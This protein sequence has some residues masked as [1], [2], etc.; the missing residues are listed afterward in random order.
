MRT[1]NVAVE[2]AAAAFLAVDGDKIRTTRQAVENAASACVET[3][4]KLERARL[5]LREHKRKG[6][7]SAG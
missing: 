6:A 3:K 4:I 2:R 5:R 1:F 7:E